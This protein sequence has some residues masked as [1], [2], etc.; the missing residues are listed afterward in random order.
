VKTI[1]SLR[2][3]TLRKSSKS[4]DKNGVGLTTARSRGMHD[5]IVYQLPQA[6]KY[7]NFTEFNPRAK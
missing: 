7:T 1:S 5:E 3:F 4:V 2:H 6:N